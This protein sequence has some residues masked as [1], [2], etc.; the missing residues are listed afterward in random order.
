MPKVAVTDY[1]FANLDPERAVLEPLGCRIEAAQCRTAEQLLPLVRDADVV[2]TQ[3]APL[4]AA[5]LA[6]MTRCRAV[7]RY[8]IGVDNVDLEAAA[9]RNIPVCNVPDYCI[10]EVA[11]H[12]LGLILALTRRLVAIAATVRAGAWNSFL[13]AEQ[14]RVL[15]ELTVGVVG[16]G[17]IGREVVRRLHALKCRVQVFDPVVPAAAVEA[18]G[19]VPAPLDVVLETS[20]LVTLHCPSTAETRHLLNRER[21]S[22]MKRGVLIVNAGRGS[23]IRTDDLVEGLRTGQVGGAALDVA[24]P[25]PLPA[26]HPLLAMDNVIVTNHVA[27]CSATAI[28]TLRTTVARTAAAALRGEPLPNVVN[29]VPR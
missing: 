29:G 14:M 12:T 19:A 1:T 4:T 18:A 11:D 17:R 7:V 6:A 21:L 9:A 8:G 28:R 3:F 22:R 16:F 15:R 13:P 25:E 27:S 23:L 10:D 20:D 2:I 24:D 26:G 5:V